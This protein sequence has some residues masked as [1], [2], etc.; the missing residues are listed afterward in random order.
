[1]LGVG[2]SDLDPLDARD[3]HAIN[4]HPQGVLHS[5]RAAYDDGL[6]G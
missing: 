3:L 1:M 2:G 6:G 4:H 5:L